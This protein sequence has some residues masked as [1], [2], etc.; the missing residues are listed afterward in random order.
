MLKFPCEIAT[1][2]HSFRK[3][4]IVFFSLFGI[5]QEL[6]AQTWI[7]SDASLNNLHSFT[8]KD[9]VG[10]SEGRVILRNYTNELSLKENLK[11]LK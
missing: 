10:Y 3:T 2:Y 1:F 7:H 9:K 4:T 6:G 5:Q 8:H 11:V